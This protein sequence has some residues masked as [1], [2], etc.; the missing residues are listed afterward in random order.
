MLIRDGSEAR[1][2]ET[3]QPIQK[4]LAAQFDKRKRGEKKKNNIK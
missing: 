3:R 2:D 1:R 4:L